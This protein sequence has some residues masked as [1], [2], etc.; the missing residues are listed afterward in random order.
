MWAR[1]GDADQAARWVQRAYEA[2]SMA[3]P[4]LGVMPAYD[5]VRDHPG[6]AAVLRRMGLI[7]AAERIG[8]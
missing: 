3:L 7:E 5:G 4:F 6:I 8:R 1:I 2:R